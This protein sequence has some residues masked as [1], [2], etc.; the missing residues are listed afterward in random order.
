MIA[1]FYTYES[2][3]YESYITICQVALLLLN[4]AYVVA[5]DVVKYLCITLKRTKIHVPLLKWVH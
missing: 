1:S 2:I 5:S 3:S 4:Q